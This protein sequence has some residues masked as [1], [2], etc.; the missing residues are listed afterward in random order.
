M[1]TRIKMDVHRMATRQGNIHVVAT[2]WSVM[3]NG[4]LME[5]RG[6]DPTLRI[7]ATG[8]RRD[9]V[10]DLS[11][12]QQS[13]NAGRCHPRP[14]PPPLQT[15]TATAALAFALAILYRELD[16]CERPVSA[17]SACTTLPA[18]PHLQPSNPSPFFP[19]PTSTA[20]S[21]PALLILHPVTSTLEPLTKCPSSPALPPLNLHCRPLPSTAVPSPCHYPPRLRPRLSPRPDETCRST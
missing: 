6:R 12:H 20:P 16:G 18:L 21:T 1:V 3:V 8:R 10:C 7:P 2:R 5:E 15:A 11:H 19:L 14:I 13:I 17:W 4:W 9:D